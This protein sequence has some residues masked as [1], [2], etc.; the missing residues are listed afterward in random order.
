MVEHQLT[1]FPP[2]MP[3]MYWVKM[4]VMVG[5]CVIRD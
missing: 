3:D 5:V 2:R 4:G 1:E